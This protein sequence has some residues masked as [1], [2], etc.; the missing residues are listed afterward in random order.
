MLKILQYNVQKRKDAVLVPLL[1]QESV[2]DIDIIAI[3][4][5][6]RN[7][8]LSTTYNA[9][10]TGF[11]LAY[12]SEEED[13][14]VCFYINKRLNTQQWE[15]THRSRDLCSMRLEINSDN[16]RNSNI[17]NIHNVYNPSP[18]STSST[19]G[20]TT[21]PQLKSMLTAGEEHIIIGDFN[22]HH[23][24]WTAPSY[25]SRHKAADQLVDIVVEE[26][27]KLLLPIGTIT[28]E[29]H[30]QRTTI[31]LA[32]ATESTANRM[33]SCGVANT[34]SMG[35]DHLPILTEWDMKT[36]K[37][38]EIHKRAWKKM[39][40]ERYTNELKRHLPS[41]RKPNTNA[42]IEQYTKEITQ[43]ISIAIAASTPWARHSAQA[44]PYW[45]TEC[46]A[47]VSQCRN[48]R[49]AAV[50]QDTQQ[51]W[52]DY[53]A[54]VN[55]KAN[56]IKRAKRKAFREAMH[57]ASNNDTTIW[58]LV[59][60]AKN[61]SHLPP[62]LPQFPPLIR[63]R[64]A[65]EEQLE[66]TFAGKVEIFKEQFFPPSPEADLSD[67]A[68][69]SYQQQ[70]EQDATITE[71]E[72]QRAIRKQGPNKA[73]GPSQIPNLA[74]QLGEELLLPHLKSIFS[75]CV[76]QGFHPRSFKSANTIVLKK[77]GKGDYRVPK[78]YR[79]IALL[80]TIGKVLESIIARRISDLAEAL[81]L[82]PACQMGARRM[83]STTTALELLVE[84]VHTVWGADRKHVATA[85]CLDMAG[86]F[87]NVSHTRL[88][89]NLKK[90]RIPEY[91]I[92][93]TASFLKDRETTL[94]FG[95]E[96]SAPLMINAGIP[97]GSPVSPILFL[98]FNAD[99]MDLITDTGLK[100]TG[101]GFVDDATLLAYSK[102]TEENC[103]ILTKV[104]QQCQQWA[105]MHGACFA[106]AK[107]ELIH[108]TR[109]PKRFNMKACIDINGCQIN[110]KADI[111][112]LGVQIDTK[113]V[114]GAHIKKIEAKMITQMQAL[115]R[116]GASTWG[117]TFARA[118]QIY[119]MVVRP[120]ITYGAEVWHTH[121]HNRPS[122]RE[123]CLTVIQNKALRFITGAFK[124]TS[125]HVLEE[126]AHI[127]PIHL[128]LDQK[129]SRAAIRMRF[130]G[131]TQEIKKECQ[132]IRTQLRSRRGRQRR[133]YNTP[134]DHRCKWIDQIIS[135]ERS[136]TT[137]QNNRR[138]EHT[139]NRTEHNSDSTNA[140]QRSNRYL[141]KHFRR[142]WESRW[143]AYQESIPEA[144]KTPAQRMRIAHD[145]IKI[146]KHLQKAESTLA[147][148][149]RTERIGLAAYL[150]SRKVPGFD[151]PNCSCG[152][153]QQT[154]KH[155]L[156]HCR[157]H[158]ARRPQLFR[159]AGTQDYRILTSTAKGLKAATRFLMIEGVLDQFKLA[160][161]LL[162][163]EAA[164]G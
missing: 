104:H 91:I 78:A 48:M 88:L 69:Y 150:Y 157:K 21:L 82:L 98:F 59:K 133:P 10:A 162:Y 151:S 20:P 6:W 118:R 127:E 109:T 68:D 161:C 64:N 17:I 119:S 23:P 159:D 56:T 28:R 31:D 51:A 158:A 47:L 60:W 11:T 83:R 110:A 9:H 106:P 84:Q 103:E 147:M 18:I 27:L 22:L 75:A 128:H 63:M 32:F 80:D 73:P 129:Q 62:D 153:F 132:K 137:E 26:N 94:S 140:Q 44:K 108:L 66:S 148:H 107:Y 79:P 72:I 65:G 43:A 105:R 115:N 155:V 55:Q 156:I 40:I 111:R 120:A 57:E 130:A 146:R 122:N 92:Q 34:L 136:K 76:S 4:E 53:Q 93:W 143:E 124:N 131:R 126:E 89:H 30:G 102:S 81:N 19:E 139:H 33:L 12:A 38:N 29:A 152:S 134:G 74:I 50:S 145:P 149:I 46:S 54:T 141:R 36:T 90:R 114:W 154:A 45:T 144:R 14:R 87:D 125:T 2:Q 116:L 15:I 135:T 3:Q 70:I 85:L 77:P 121:T 86:A 7:A 142:Q 58:K 112:V 39:D 101:I 5:P 8:F 35:S 67:I 16:N 13:T 61:R 97:Q 41:I 164:E 25:L 100:S 123:K 117:A 24:L 52:H 42:E 71:E 95:G 113:L 163:G 1:H 37:A 99:L 49:R 138:V 160:T 96:T